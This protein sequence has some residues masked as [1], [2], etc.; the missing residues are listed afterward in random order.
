[1]IDT[2]S[3]IRDIPQQ[4]WFGSKGRDIAAIDVLDHAVADEAVPRLV[5]TLV[6]IAY[7]DGGS[8]LYHLPLLVD[9]DGSVRDAT[10]DVERLKLIG[11]LM[12]QGA[13][14]KGRHGA[15]EFSGG[16][17]DPMSPPGEQS[18]RTVGAEQSNSSIVLD[19][20]V[21]VKL[22]RRVEPGPNP[23]LE[24]NRLLTNEG[25]DN[26]PAQVGEIIYEGAVDDEELE[27]GI[28]IAQ[29]FLKDARE[30][31]S[32]T[33]SALSSLYEQTS[34]AAEPEV[35]EV[36]GAASQILEQIEALG[37]ATGSLHVLLSRE[38]LEPEFAPQPVESHDL[39]EWADAAVASLRRLIDQGVRELEPLS[40]AIERRIDVLRELPDAGLKLRIHGDYHLGQ[41]M[42][43][44]RGWAILDFEGEPARP[45][46]ERR[47]RQS[48]LRDV[49]GMLRSFSYAAV[50]ALFERADLDSDTW[51]ALQPWADAWEQLARDRF[52]G[53]YLSRSHEAD[54]LPAERDSISAMLDVF[55]IDKALYEVGYERSHR[56][57]WVRIP[58]RGIEQAIKR[59]DGL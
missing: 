40:D 36:E 57:E 27:I 7:A 24:I 37:E 33:L 45:L 1:M 35:E 43:G 2:Q 53:A 54:F 39:R 10:Q 16:G 58:L 42:L 34:D 49:A 29:E 12:S 25:F 41:V 46:E 38:G 9:D 55:E 8:D 15:F 11:R 5:L 56:P 30:G 51:K 32:E 4:R 31:W 21:I 20:S 13:S 6:R 17:L 18:I 14:L 44:T 26:I 50:A 23:D 22:F 28:G 52:L 59:G 48:P 3:L 19:E 47:E